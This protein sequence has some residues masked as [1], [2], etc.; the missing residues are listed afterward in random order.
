MIEILYVLL[1]WIIVLYI[2]VLFLLGFV[3]YKFIIIMLFWYGL[4]I[5]MELCVFRLIFFLMKS[6]EGYGL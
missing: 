1:Y 5:Y 4:I 3:F 6:I 2:G